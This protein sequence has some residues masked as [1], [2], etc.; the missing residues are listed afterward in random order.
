[1]PVLDG[2]HATHMLRHHAPFT[3]I[4][5]IPRIPI[6][7]MTASAIQG[8]REKCEKAGMDDYMAKPVK[9]TL[10]ESTILKWVTRDRAGHEQTKSTPERSDA[11]KPNLERACTDHSSTCTQ[12]DAIAR[13]FFDQ[14]STSAQKVPGSEFSSSEEDRHDVNKRA[15]RRSSISRAILESEI[16]GG[17][18]EG[19]RA[20]RRAA[21]EDLAQALRDAKLLSATDL[22]HGQSPGVPVLRVEDGAATELHSTETQSKEQFERTSPLALTEE[23]VFLLNHTAQSDLSAKERIRSSS[24]T[25]QLVY[26]LSDIPGPPPEGAHSPVDLSGAHTGTEALVSSMLETAQMSLTAPETATPSRRE[27]GGLLPESRQVSDWSTSTARPE[28]GRS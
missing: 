13:E 18:T 9:R 20:V 28:Q 16:P 17:E 12:H 21:A 24:A 7:A 27:V 1:M 5:A 2:Y 8:D 10:L 19:D 23:N 22:E 14:V 6:V 25:S 3:Q 26:P 4:E 15:A 11:Q